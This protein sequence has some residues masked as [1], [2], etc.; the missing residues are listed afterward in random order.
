MVSIFNFAI[1]DTSRSSYDPQ[2]RQVT[3]NWRRGKKRRK[4]IS[5]R[6]SEELEELE[7]F[8]GGRQFALQLAAGTGCFRAVI[9]FSIAEVSCFRFR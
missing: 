4:N 1:R 6:L 7:L 9:K 8:Q 3:S 2:R 5:I